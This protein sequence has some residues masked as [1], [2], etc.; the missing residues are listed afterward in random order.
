[1]QSSLLRPLV[2]FFCLF[3]C[4]SVASAQITLCANTNLT[5]STICPAAAA[6][7]Q[8]GAI[9]YVAGTGFTGTITAANTQVTITPPPGNG[10]PVLVTAAFITNTAASAR[11]VGFVIPPSLTTN[12]PINCTVSVSAT[13]SL[14]V[15]ENSNNTAALTINPPPTVLSAS[16]GAG[17]LGASVTLTITGSFTHFSSGT[18]VKLTGPGALGST[19]ILQTGATVF[20][21]A[22]PFHVKAS[23]NI[24]AGVPLGSYNVI[25]K[26]GTETASLTG[27]FLITSS[28]P[29]SLSSIVPNSLA[30]GQSTNVAVVGVNTHF[31]QGTTVASFG[32]G[33]TPGPVTVVDA[34]HANFNI[35]IDP[36]A[37]LG[38][39]TLTMTTGGEFATG[40]FTITT[41]GSFL[42]T[43]QMTTGTG[44][45]GTNATLTL[46]GSSSPTTH[47]IQAGTVISVGG[48]I[49][50]GNIVV[51]SPTSLTVN[52]SIGPNVAP[53]SYP[54]TATTNGEIVTKLNAVTVIPATPYLQNVSPNSGQQ[55]Q[56]H[57]LVNFTGVFTT[58][59]TTTNG[60]LNAN[61]GPNITV[62]SVVANTNT[63]ATADITISNTAAAGG[64][65]CNLNSNGVIYNF[66]FTVTPSNASLVSATPGSGLQG[67]SVAL[68]VTGSNTHWQQGLTFP[69]L[70]GGITVNRTIINSATTAEVDI[71][72]AATASIGQKTL[73]MSTG[74]EIVSLNNAFAVLPITPTMTLTPT[75]GMIAVAPQ[76]NNIVNV[77]FIGNF[78]HFNAGT[79][80]AAIDG[81][82]VTIQNFTV[83]NK[84]NATAQFVISQTAPASP[85]V[86]CT[87][88]YGGNRTVT[89]ETPI[90]SGAE[91]LYA[92]FCVTST[93]AVLTSITPVQSPEPANNLQVTITGA[94]THFESGV[95]SVGFG[96][97]I[98]V[99]PGTINVVNATT[100]KATINIASTAVLGWRPVF[101]NTIDA[102][103]FIN[104][105]LTIGF[106]LSP[107]ATATLVSV[108]PNTGIQ[109]QSM[110]VQITGNLTNWSQGNTTALFGAGITVNSLTINSAASATAQI[111]I[112]PVNSPLGGSPVTMVTELGGGVEEVVSGPIFSVTQGI[113][114][115]SLIGTNCT[116]NEVLAV[117][118][119]CQPHQFLVH[120]GDILTFFVN[121]TNTHFLQGETTLDF[122][123]DIAVSQLQVLSPTQ[124][125]CQIAVAY[126][127]TIGFRGVKAVT[128]AENALSFSD[129]L[130]VE[131]V[132][133][134][135]V[136][137]TP[138]SAKQGTVFLMQLNGTNTHWT[139]TAANPLNNTQVT[140]GNNNGVTATVFTDATH[141]LTPTQMF[142]QVTVNGTAAGVPYAFYT[143]T[144]TT[145]GLPVSQNSP[146]GIEQIILNNVLT[147]IPGDAIITQVTPTSGTQQST[148]QINVTGQNTNFLTG[149]TTAAY[150]TGGCLPTS[151][152]GINVTNVTASDHLHATLAIAVSSTAPTGFQTLCM[153]TGGEVVSFSN[154]FQVLP[155]TPTLNQVSPVSGQQGQTLTNVQILG[156]FT[157]WTSTAANPANNTTMTFGQG[158]SVQ[159]LV[160]TGPTSATA[161]LV[162]DPT[163]FLG[164]RTT[165][166]TTG[167]EI[168]QA[169]L[170]SVTVSDAIISTI[171]PTSANQGQ[172]ILL[173]I[174]GN[175]THW[176][177]ELTQ[178]AISGGGGDI[179]VNGVII[180]SP[181]QAIAD[182]SIGGT[183][184]LGTRSIYMSTTGENVSL[185]NALLITGGIPSIANISPGNGTRGDVGDNII[186][187]GAFTDKVPWS[188]SSVVDFGDPCIT[189]APIGSGSTFN[190]QLSITAV[191]NVKNAAQGCASALGL[192]TVTVRTG[193]SI[194][195]G[196]FTVYDP[197]APPTPYISYENPSVALVGQTL[198]VNFNGAFTH[199][200]TG[201][202]TVNFGAGIQVN[203]PLDV[204]G[205]GS[206]TANIT[207]QP[208]ATVGPRTVTITTGA[209]QLTTTFYVTVGVPQ[210]TLVSTNTAIQGE[211]RLL[212]LVG[213]FTTWTA[214]GPNP[215]VFQFCP[216]VDSVSN[217]QIFGPTAA[218]LQ[219]VVD[220][221]ATVGFCSVTA[222]TGAEVAHLGG[223]GFFAI[224]PSTAVISSVTPN[225][226]IQGTVGLTVDVVGF[227]TL[228]DNS[229]AFSFTGGVS[230]T[231]TT[232]IDNTH[233]TLK[234]DV[235]LFASPGFVTLN[236]HTGGQIATLNN[237]FVV[238]PGR[239]IL[240]SATNGTNQQQAAFN[241]GLLGQ[242]TNW[243]NA[244]TTVTFPNGGVTGVNVN[245]TSGQ[246][247]TV[248]GTVLATAFPGCNPIV[249]T[250]QG[251][252]PPVLSLYAF[253]IIAGPA[254]ITQLSPNNLGQGQQGTIQITGT[255]T[256]WVQ[257]TTQGNFGQGVSINT[258]TINSATSATANVTVAANA[259]PQA[260]SVTLT[261]A[262]ETATDQAAFTIFAAT[263]VLLD[264]FPNSGTQGQT[265]DVCITGAFTHFVNGNTT[266]D[267]GP[268]ITVNSTTI[269]PTATC[270][271]GDATHGDAN[272]TIQPTAL[273][274]GTNHVRMITNIGGGAQEIAIWENSSATTQFNF[275]ISSGGASILSAVPTTPAT[276]H[277]NDVGD[278]IVITG[279]GTHFNAVGQTPNVAFC[280]GVTPNGQTVNSDTKITV[281][282]NVSQFAPVGACG[283]TVT[284][285]GEVASKQNAFSILAGLP[286]ITQV[287]PNTVPQG[288]NGATINITGLYTHFTSGGLLVTLPAGVA[289]ATGPTANT[290]TSVT[291]TVNVNPTA[292]TGT[293]AISVAD[294]TDGTINLNNGFT[295]STGQPSIF[296][297]SPNTG[298][299]GSTQSIT[300]TGNYTAW[301]ASSLVGVSG[302]GDVVVGGGATVTNLANG[303]QQTIV[304]PFTVT[305]GAAATAR[306][307]T[308]Q[309]GAQVLSLVNSFTVQA[310]VPN[311]TQ[312]HPNIGVPG[313]T[314]LQVTLTGSFTNWVNG[315]TTANFGAGISVN[316]F[317]SGNTGVIQV[318]SPTSAVA[319]LTIDAGA[320]LGTRNVVV[321]TGAQI[322]TVT[323]GFTVQSTTTTPPTVLFVSPANNSSGAPINTHV[324]VV[325]SEPIDPTTIAAGNAFITD[326]TTQGG[327]WASSGLPQNA[328]SPSL[329]A[330]GRVMTITLAGNLAVGRTFWLQ[331]NSF[332]MP[333]G[334]PTISD[335]SGNHLSPI[336]DNFGTGFAVDNNGPTF[337][338]ANMANGVTGVPTNSKVYLGFDKP[339]NP[340][341]VPAGLSIQQAGNPVNGT[342]SY[343]SDF[344]Q[345]IFTP[346]GNL[347]SPS[348]TYTVTYSAAITDAVGNPLT[349]PGTLTFTTGTGTD[350]SSLT[351]V[352]ITPT[353]GATTGTNPT[354]RV[355]FNRPV[356]PLTVTPSDFYLFNQQN[357]VTVLGQ[358]ITH[359]ADNKTFTI[360][361]SGPLAASTQYRYVMGTVYDWTGQ[362]GFFNYGNIFTTGTAADSTS[363]ALNTSAP[364][365]Y[366]V[367]PGSGATNVPV[368]PVIYIHFT[369]QVSPGVYVPAPI[370]P[371]TLTPTNISLSPAAAGTAAFVSGDPSTLTFTPSSVLATATLYT[372]NVSGFSD[373]DG[374]P[375]TPFAG[376]S[377]TTGSTATADT[378][379]GTITVTPTNGA[380]LVPVNTNV[381]FQ[382]NKPA[383]PLTV[384][385]RSIYVY[386][387]S[388]SNSPQVPGTTT[389][390]ADQ[391][392]ITF[393]PTSQYQPNHQICIGASYFASFYDLAGNNFNA[394]LQCFTTGTGADVTAPTVVSVSPLN[395]AT[396]IGP[397]NPVMVTFSESMNPGSLTGNVALYNGSTLVT[398]GYSTSNDYTTLIFNNSY[399]AFSTTYTV[400]VSPN[401]TDLAG[402]QLSPGEFRSTFTTGPAP[403]TT[404]PSVTAMRPGNGATGVSTTTPIT[405]FMSAAM[406]PATVN[407]NSLKIS[408]NGVL[409][410]GNI[411][412]AAGNQDVVFTPNGGTFQAGALIQV[413][414]TSA[415]TD[416]TGNPLFNFQSSFR[417]AADLSA[418]PV[419]AVSYYPCQYCTSG[420]DRNTVVEILMTKP[421]QTPVTSSAFYVTDGVN[422]ISG[423]IS[424]LDNNRLL[425]F[426]PS[427]PLTANHYYYV[428]LTSNVKDTN[429]LS[430]A[431]ASGYYFYTGTTTNLAPPSV[432]ATAPTNGAT[433]IGPNAVIGVTFSENVDI[434]TLDPANVT[435]TGPGGSIPLT[436]SYNSST[437]SMTVTPQAPMPPSASITLTLNGVTDDD[438]NALS[439]TPYNLS[440]TTGATPDF[441][442]PVVTQTNVSNGQGG[443]PVTTSF[444][445]TFNK[446]ID[447]RTVIYGNTVYLQDN[448]V[449]GT[450]PAT[451]SPVGS[452][453]FLVTPTS[454]LGVNRNYQLLGCQIADLNGNLAGCYFMNISFTS[455]LTAPVG[456]PVVTQMIPANGS[457]G[458]PANFKP[459]V[460]FDRPVNPAALGGITLTHSGNPV[461]ATPVLSQGNTVV[462]LVPTSILS[463]N[464]AYVFTVTGTQD[465]AGNTQ[466]GSVA[467]SFTTGVSIDLVQPTVTSATPI[468]NSTTG[469]NPLVQLTFSE[470]I[471]IVS[472]TSFAFGN[473]QTGANVNGTV[474]TWSADYRTVQFTYPGALDPNTRYYFFLSY[475][476]LAGNTNS[477]GY[478]YFYTNSST[479]T[480]HETVTSITPP[481]TQTGVPLN[482]VMTLRLAKPAAPGSVNA[483][484]VTLSPSVAGMTVQLS[485]DGM[486]IT[487]ARPAGTNLVASTPYTIT[488]PSGGFT[489]ENGNPVDPA[490]S[491]FT[492][493]TS[494][495]SLSGSI[496][497][498]NPSSGSLGASLTQPITITL[499]KAW[500]PNSLTGNFFAVFPNNNGNFPIAGTI[501]TCPQ[502]LATCP[503]V[504]SV[505]LQ[506]NTMVFTPS[507]AW[508]SNSTINIYVGYYSNIQDLAGNNF[509][510][511]FNATFSTAST[512]DNT[513]PAVINSGVTPAN[514][515]T[516]VGPNAT[517]AITFNKSLDYTTINSANFVLYNGPTNLNAGVSYSFDRSIVYLSTT[518][519]YSSTI[520]VAVST[521]VKDYN[522]NN[523]ASP[524]TS[525]FSTVQL[526]LTSTPSITQARPTGSGAALNNSITLYSSSPMSLPAVQNG[527][528]V[529]QNGALINGTITLTADLHGIIWTPNVN[530][531]PGAL[532]QVYLYPP[533]ADISG[534]VVNNF[535]YS[536][537]TASVPGPATAPTEVAYS[538]CKYCQITILNPSI[539]VQFS[540]PLNPATVTSASAFVKL[541][542]AGALLS[543]TPVVL[544]GGYLLRIPLTGPLTAN[545]FYYYITLTTA[546]QD[547]DGNP[548]ASDNYYFYTS[549]GAASDST[550]P[551]VSSVTPINGA[552]GI[553]DNASVR[554][555]FSKVMDTLTI[556]PT[557]VSILHGATSLP[558]TVTFGT[559][560]NAGTQTVATLMP[561]APLPDNA[562]ITVQLTGGSNGI[563]DSAGNSISS[564]S[565]TF[566]TASGA[567]FSGPVVVR[568]SVD[569]HNNSA[570]P[571]NSTFTLVFN[572]PLDPSTVSAAGFY[573]Y[574]YSIGT[575]PSHFNVSA[576]G[577]SVTISPNSN[578]GASHNMYYDWCYETDLNGNTGVCQSQGFITSSS[579]DTTAPTVVGSNPVNNNT[580]APTNS[581]IEVIFSEAVRS[582]SL[583]SITL[584]AGAVSV[585]FTAV[586][587]NSAYTDDTVIRLIPQQLLSP[588][589]A[590]TVSVSGVQDVAG[591]TMAGT[592]SFTFTT[593]NNFQI[594][595]LLQ[596]T[597]SVTTGSGTVTLPSS[598]T[599]PNVLDNP[600][601]T[602]VFDHGVDLASLLHNGINLR[603]T[604]YNLVPGVTLNFVLST[605]QK[606]V[607]ITTSGLAGGTTYRLALQ[608]GF[609]LYDESG[610]TGTNVFYTFTTQ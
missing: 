500:N 408:Q 358:T 85:A 305:N 370:D 9:A 8:P 253:C 248:T 495:D 398:S 192:H 458:V 279:S 178:F 530:Y 381:V 190:S 350:T 349:N 1:M 308:V 188:P 31:V 313:A 580:N 102:G 359:S 414:F 174:N 233:A 440:F 409:L 507:V 471:N 497:L 157:H 95:T 568:Q 78:T 3:L 183:A 332:G 132:Q 555:V 604:S 277:Q 455:T 528:Y 209:Q 453:G 307:V 69:S 130:D 547:T 101:V 199:W 64:R 493:G 390:S 40:T 67:T 119:N 27:G 186:I 207:I 524:F 479:D 133:G 287:N 4:V 210:I 155:G 324:T 596:P 487:L 551:T 291:M 290:D 24:P 63:S 533:A 84:F 112:D 603:D 383:D 415:A 388:T 25:A 315:T 344:L 327:C 46:T 269:A 43:V 501:T 436:I 420:I 522:G 361:L 5:Q 593:G 379:H 169:N 20:N 405:L 375:M 270:P 605:D 516:N 245:V 465:S 30:A 246:S 12:T 467:R 322:L 74:G 264:V 378:S 499:S 588:N 217:V 45:Q 509:S 539:E 312:I 318:N 52:I 19:T 93:P 483:S 274:N 404:Q 142:L 61:F 323:N 179:K 193:T 469:T 7:V 160:I 355:V 104:E 560:N 543:G 584:Q 544:N 351:W 152:A 44:A 399:L 289:I 59:Q 268:G 166:V 162:I 191:I 173:Q 422:P 474:L 23:F 37:V 468:S 108:L 441:S 204:T 129:A 582:T 562:T 295:I 168:V 316:G 389:L 265:M 261:T 602:L 407:A 377:F 431:G 575:I 137:A 450:V 208:G 120:Q 262:G 91:I 57:L 418:T 88:I 475:A 177:Q 338:S 319:T 35:S 314:S 167:N 410:A 583:G 470:P 335:Q 395:G 250:T 498:T 234:V 594:S 182:L 492:T 421:L 252:N 372:V 221:L 527:M 124:I 211:T 146:Q 573:I 490:S 128:N 521:N 18:T 330:S 231:Q 385:S 609:N 227:A 114:A 109:G 480:T 511:L 365:V 58:F 416:T 70:G 309:T 505:Q 143:L 131:A 100:V 574:D 11:A 343:T 293:F 75:A 300:I 529:S 68:Q 452:N 139:N 151:P 607:T 514:G 194:Q 545:T 437:F 531:Q 34:T 445:V 187:T 292:T 401:A 357:G 373:Q 352:S 451:I 267:F 374:N 297:V 256:N 341:T 240:L 126:T 121:G 48:G 280:S 15:V 244:N 423:I 79:T 519:P 161:T 443:V 403:V 298:A 53:G 464:T 144:I 449:G 541:N 333:G 26:S 556:N 337:V 33:I 368:N 417:I 238:Q 576:D 212:D 294:T 77:N 460:R 197:A 321:T 200:L 71:T 597:A 60:P 329:D 520:T 435:L 553:G 165:T 180:N 447:M 354:L 98:T 107:P 195:T 55:G 123:P 425:R 513:P 141:Q 14:N 396:G 138:T 563:I 153:Y 550:P 461:S 400:V 282:V 189:V 325:F 386:D 271:T 334:T 434:N 442:G 412:L 118:N 569:G 546:I 125:Q 542:N 86:P 225:T 134:V 150:S 459:M 140:F 311:V 181:T 94:F 215:T 96:P 220:P 585:P 411:T 394:V 446:P 106:Y 54:V 2:L 339:I 176:S 494:T 454:L 232:V 172:H 384:N 136:N 557:T 65:S 336:C 273:T 387:N 340:A 592:S 97:D 586:M 284:T 76:V 508:P 371:T 478:Q 303:Y 205:I 243:T 606:T 317:G 22:D 105:Q 489:D 149:V 239:P 83:L 148:E 163:A 259:T 600:T 10:S 535:S 326:N 237:A 438:G 538:P 171:N 21:A 506:H 486:T 38:N 552:T 439:P 578:M 561:Q 444:S 230:V 62:N 526:P 462:T 427:S 581:S 224:T 275:A 512:A 433:A 601:F 589:T 536:F 122:G 6:A 285:G 510:S 198:A 185:Q 206:A 564:Q 587:N 310:G 496:T 260:N 235:D 429:N 367:S 32:D 219:V 281:S 525:T 523:M 286:V 66:T 610:N 278:T 456:G 170:F 103:N 254:A 608:Y 89:V 402:N 488:V 154:A 345:A 56:Q 222:T 570:V 391:K 348:L 413:F 485:A 301:T 537:H 47:W 236:A 369:K 203:G 263:P 283:V 567:D 517:V 481:N 302:G 491:T 111:S 382:L 430:Y 342:W 223:G 175:F 502:S 463:P 572:K 393:T 363:P 540:K 147:V 424:T 476:D 304:V 50:V 419:T 296:S 346:A 228:W 226:A 202:T 503:T 81:N 457:T 590:Y 41:N 448:T 347:L 29:L 360:N 216:G 42:Q 73:T 72:I 356:D 432:I 184:N 477:F 17:Q 213:Q 366:G 272:I 598:G 116:A 196:Q 117:A 299:Q 426:T 36:I 288:T 591:N 331:L 364:T 110:A 16:P 362:N 28:G 554:L 534:N 565:T 201:Q 241:I 251:Q 247:I 559:L 266:A 135:N 276:V 164:S 599:L 376:S 482:A 549:S 99:I 249:V 328:G 380:T 13:N 229:T 466:S 258:L 90:G 92:G 158:V 159:N 571:V 472:S 353:S 80:I 127:A 82:G 306:T 484:S 49:N 397:S 214:S 595:G 577:L 392:T 579:A 428:Y 558:Y 548:F 87:N 255:N 39:R 218:R 113:A 145:S 518:L 115:I 51:S 320:A 532:I 515:A 242:F 257:G 566:T 406:N 473:N 504:N 156:Q